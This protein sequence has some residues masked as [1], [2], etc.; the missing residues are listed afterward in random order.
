LV[1]VV[2]QILR[3]E[4]VVNKFVE[5]FGP[6]VSTMQLA[7]R[8]TIANMAPEYGAT[9][10]FFPI[11]GETLKYLRRTGRADQD[12]QLV[13][14]YAKEQGLFRPDGGPTPTFTKMLSLDLGTVEPSLAGPKR[15]QDRVPLKAMKQSFHDALAAP[16]AQRGFALDATAQKRAATVADNGRSN[17][18][19]H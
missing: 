6:G 18:I 5:F 8:A 7:D 15:P 10:G 14:R 19:T 3:K 1:L 17:Q 12:V 13:E 9:M 2:T 11:D 16:V 4:G